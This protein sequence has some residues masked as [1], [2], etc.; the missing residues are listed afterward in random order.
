MSGK[1]G[2]GAR[3]G[4][5]NGGG[6]RARSGKSE[7]KDDGNGQLLLK[8]DGQEYGKIKSM[9][10]DSH[11]IVACY[12]GK[13]RRGKIR[14]K[15][16]KKKWMQAGDTVIVGIRG[17]EDKVCDIIDK[18]TPQDVKRLH[19]QGELPSLAARGEGDDGIDFKDDED[20]KMRIAE[21]VFDFE[22]L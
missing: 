6:K 21:E 16:R 19:A 11:A 7:S 5:G 12:D 20:E 3:G 2:G 1:K 18:Y 10:G 13:D 17:F 8:E 15:L 22:S 9:T 4:K 14:G